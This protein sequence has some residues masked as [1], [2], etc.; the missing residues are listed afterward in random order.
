MV[1]WII[2]AKNIPIASAANNAKDFA[3]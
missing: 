1:R 2:S 3:A